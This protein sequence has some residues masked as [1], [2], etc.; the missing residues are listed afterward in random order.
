MISKFSLVTFFI[1]IVCHFSNAQE[2]QQSNVTITDS[3]YSKVLNEYREIY[4]KIPESYSAN[5]TL[6]YPVAYVLDGDVMLPTATLVHSYYSGGFMPEMVL[7][8]IS[9]TKHRERDL[10]TSKVT[11]RHG[12]EY[13]QE[14]GE[15]DNFTQFIATELIP[16]IEKNYP[17]TSYKT[18]I[19]HS[20]GGL[21]TI[22][23]LIHHSHL[24]ENYLAIDPS[25][26]WDDQKLLKESKSIF[27]S[28]SFKGKSLFITLGGQLHM[29]NPDITIDN[30]MEDTSEFTLFSRSNIAFSKLADSHA[31]NGL[32][33]Q[34][35]FYP[36]DLHG[37]IPLPSIMDGLVSMFQ[38]YQM[39]NTDK[40]NNPETPK[41][42]LYKIVK[43][44]E[45]KLAD[46][47]GY[48]TAPY[49][50]GLFNMLGYMS[51][52]MGNPKKSLMFFELATAYFPNSANAFDSLADYYESQKEYTNALKNVAKAYELSGNDYHKKRIESFKSKL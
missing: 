10:T 49:E 33:S 51:L 20:Y 13:T 31:N 29:Q 52:D 39:E 47:F 38:W 12:M 24:F 35:K 19:G 6:N 30:V 46:H 9:N 28:K 18:L 27:T 25:L 42:D 17:V 44:R 5:N 2:N 34:W 3:I 36:N 11:T 15:A 1:L 14:N 23:T 16:Y 26:D 22:N 48:T 45:E 7:I 8:G 43:Y 41:E 37:T 21:F 40:F 32:Q 50:E 4:I